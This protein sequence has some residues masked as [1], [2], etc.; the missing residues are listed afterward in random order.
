MKKSL[1]LAIGAFAL[2]A[3]Y[4]ATLAMAQD[5]NVLNLYNWSDYRADDTLTNFTKQTGIKVVEA[6]YDSNEM[7]EGKLVAGHSGYDVVV[8]S[9]FFL[10]HQ[11]PIGLYQKL[12]KSK[13]PNLK[14]MDPAIMKATNAFDPGNQYAVDYMWGTTALGYNVDKVKAA[15]PNAPLDSWDLLFK[16]ENAAK[17]KDCGITVLDAPSEVVAIALNYLGLDPNSEKP[18][19]LDKAEKLL[20]TVKP[21]I[22]KFDSSGYIDDLANGD[23]CLSLGYSGDVYI[24]KHRAE[25]AKNNVHIQYLIPKEGT[26][27]WFDMLAIPADAPHPENALKFINYIMDGKVTADISNNVF[28]ANGNTAAF[29]LTD[30]AITGDPNIYPPTDLQAK[31]TPLLSHSQGFTRLLTRTWTRIK[32]GE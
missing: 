27:E 26:I 19:D 14:N 22:R 20:D 1:I 3:P 30:K 13:L 8:P 5:D 24:A 9:G 6:N 21:Y 12:D 16:P 7:L 25:D 18:E 31:L 29:P 11:I 15:L 10:Q 23:A 17:L 2:A 4:T 28:Y 32:T